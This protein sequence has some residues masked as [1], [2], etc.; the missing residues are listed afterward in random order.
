VDECRWITATQREDLMAQLN[1]A[2]E[3][4]DLTQE[5]TDEVPTGEL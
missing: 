4:I 5:L 1:G 3:G 2:S